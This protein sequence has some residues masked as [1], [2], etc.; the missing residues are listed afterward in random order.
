MSEADTGHFLVHP[1][2]TGAG[3]MCLHACPKGYCLYG[4]Q[5]DHDQGTGVIL[6]SLTMAAKGPRVFTSPIRSPPG[7]GRAHRLPAPLSR[8]VT[9]PPFR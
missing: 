7:V 1:H 4:S 6:C 8:E 3:I 2:L 9:V 5:S